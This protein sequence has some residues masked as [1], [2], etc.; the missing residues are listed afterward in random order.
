MTSR[1]SPGTTSSRTASGGTSSR[2]TAGTR[3]TRSSPR[4][5]LFG[6]PQR[7]ED[8]ATAP[9]ARTDPFAVLPATFAALREAQ[10]AAAARLTEPV[11][12]P[13]P[14]PVETWGADVLGDG[15]EARTLLLTD[16]D[17]GPVVA[18][19]VRLPGEATDRSRATPSFAVLYVH[20]WN[21]YFFQTE[22]ARFWR[23]AGGAF[24][25]LDLRKY[26]RSLRAHQSAGYVE[27][28]ETYDEDLE[29]ALA[30]IAEEH[31]TDLPLVIN[32]HST[33]GLVTALW[34]HRNPGRV[35]A[36][37]LNSPWLEVL[38]TQFVRNL[39]MPVVD[40]LARMQPKTP[41]PL[42]DPGY[43]ARSLDVKQ[44]GEWTF[45]ERWR[46]PES[47]PVRPGWMRAILT[48]HARVAAGLAIEAP[49]L[50]LTS[51][52]TLINPVWSEEMR[53]ADIVLDVDLVGRRALH[54]GPV[55]T[56]V[57]VEGALHDVILSAPPVRERAYAEI[58]RWARA[59]VETR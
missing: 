21:D 53:T 30:I 45:D 14:P 22:L 12:Y 13:T 50:V 3:P 52:R 48:G 57:R 28:L 37:V 33:G 40:Q 46:F 24:Y 16:D 4:L 25:A 9:Q 11:E 54:L 26:G 5:T 23:E 31:G 1:P 58:R 42:V 32:A 44:G 2:T 43:Y 38:G 36:L 47:M 10:R 55:V 15:F 41:L 8:D 29:A 18:T 20:G 51:A 59:Y 49:I 6:P 56:V 19:L 35:A 17:E 7:R 34:A 39:S 27:D